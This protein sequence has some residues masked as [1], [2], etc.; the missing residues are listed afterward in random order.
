MQVTS[1]GESKHLNTELQQG[2]PQQHM[3]GT[4]ELYLARL[5]PRTN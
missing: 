2:Q 4:K 3:Q 1:S 5:E